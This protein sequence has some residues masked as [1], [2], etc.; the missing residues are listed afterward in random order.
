MNVTTNCFVHCTCL[1]RPGSNMQN[2]IV[3]LSTFI[4]Y[5]TTN[6]RSSYESFQL[7]ARFKTFHCFPQVLSRARFYKLC[8]CA[9]ARRCC[10]FWR[11]RRLLLPQY[12]LVWKMFSFKGVHLQCASVDKLIPIC[13]YIFHMQLIFQF[14][15]S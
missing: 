1:Q 14:A 11:C 13:L 3:L 2:N 9:R 15:L 12:R 6:R 7:L 10:S 8:E 4:P 5:P